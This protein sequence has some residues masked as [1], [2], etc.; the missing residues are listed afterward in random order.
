MK[1][2]ERESLRVETIM[3]ERGWSMKMNSY[4][5][6][7]NKRYKI[8]SS[9]LKLEDVASYNWSVLEECVR[10][11]VPNISHVKFIFYLFMNSRIDKIMSTFSIK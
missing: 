9:L 5:P 1:L 3:V 8:I 11:C 10:G 2:P 4:N 7:N 6:S